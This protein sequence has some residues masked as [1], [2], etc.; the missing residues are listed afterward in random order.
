MIRKMPLAAS[1][2]ALGLAGLGVLLK[3]LSPLAWSVCGALALTLI[4]L[5]IARFML[6]PKPTWEEA[7][8]PVVH[9]TLPA[10]FMSLTLLSTYL[11][12]VA[13][14]AATAL[15]W[16]VLVAQLAV[17]LAF[18][19]KYLPK[20]ELKA[21]LPSWFLVFV[22]F[23][24]SAVTSPA[25]GTQRVG[26]ALVWIGL[27]GY[28]VSLPLV[29]ARLV[30]VGELPTPAA[31]LVAITTAPPALLIA[32]YLSASPSPEPWLVMALLGF[33]A[34]SFI[35]VLAKAPAVLRLGFLPSMGALTFPVVISATALT[36]A[37]KALAG[38]GWL[39][40]VVGVLAPSVTILAAIVVIYVSA[41][42]AAYLVKLARS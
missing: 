11:V 4:A 33:W 3:P 9:S 22:G 25:F 39:A 10:F 24:V 26:A 14:G 34:I 8:T 40:S 2:L 29:V 17:S 42:Y 6:D 20:L 19:V 21:V 23:V 32:G 38:S 31:P 36:K 15:W 12:P 27:A 37:A 18:A 13:K 5:L 1:G 35:F 16:V 7:L 30:K 28:A 41:R